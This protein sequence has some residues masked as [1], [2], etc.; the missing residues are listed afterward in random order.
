MRRREGAHGYEFL[1]P[2]LMPP[3]DPVGRAWADIR[4]SDTL[5]LADVHAFAD[6]FY[7]PERMTV[8][9]LGSDRRRLGQDVLRVAARLV[10]RRSEAA[11]RA[12]VR[13]PV[14]AFGGRRARRRAAAAARRRR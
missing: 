3:G 1:V 6:A 14:A 9:D 13:R 12:P 2:A 11:R 10:A 4:R 8:V 7:R 5:S